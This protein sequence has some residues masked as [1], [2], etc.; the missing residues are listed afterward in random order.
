MGKASIRADSVGGVGE[1][2]VIGDWREKKVRWK[3]KKKKTNT[4]IFFYFIWREQFHSIFI[5]TVNYN[6]NISND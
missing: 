1:G 5:L 4:G 6:L 3:R 2:G